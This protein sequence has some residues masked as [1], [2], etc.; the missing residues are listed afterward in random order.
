MLI[1]EIVEF[2]GIYSKFQELAKQRATCNRI[3]SNLRNEK[4]S[5]AIKNII[6]LKNRHLSLFPNGTKEFNDPYS[7]NDQD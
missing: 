6:K 3:L 2:N 4:Y 1:F 5:D 7:N